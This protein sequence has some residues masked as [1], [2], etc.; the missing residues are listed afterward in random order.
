MHDFKDDNKILSFDYFSYSFILIGI[1]D[2]LHYQPQERQ[3]DLIEGNGREVRVIK[4][5]A[6]RWEDVATRLYFD[7]DDIKCI[8]KDNHYI[9]NP[10]CREMFSL[11]LKGKGRRPADWE[12]LIKALREAEFSELVEE[13]QTILLS[14]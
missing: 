4:K 12:T 10:S 11:W 2:I 9:T 1:A 3:L 7:L 6:S 13:V 8:K 14:K 5:V